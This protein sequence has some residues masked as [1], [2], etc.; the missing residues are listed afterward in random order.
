MLA[1]IVVLCS[2]WV[3]A[4]RAEAARKADAF[5]RGRVALQELDIVGTRE[6]FNAL[7]DDPE[8]EAETVLLRAGIL[9]ALGQPRQAIAELAAVQVRPD[10]VEDA[11]LLRANAEWRTGNAVASIT[12]LDQLTRRY[13]ASRLPQLKLI[14]YYHAIGAIDEAMRRCRALLSHH[15]EDPHVREM[16]A[17]MLHRDM[18]FFGD[19]AKE[20]R[21]A[22]R[23]SQPGSSMDQAR[24]SLLECLVEL[25]EYEELLQEAAL[26]PESP[27]RFTWQ[28]IAEKALDRLAD[29]EASLKLALELDPKYMPALDQYGRL[30]VERR[31]FAAAAEKFSVAVSLDE[32]DHKMRYRLAQALQF[33]GEKEKAAAEFEKCKASEELSRQM[34]LLYS[35]AKENPADFET[36][37]KLVQ[38]AEKMGRR[39][40]MAI[41]SQAAAQSRQ[42]SVFG[43]SPET[44][45]EA[46]AGAESSQ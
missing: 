19:A 17:V 9:T 20:Y 39:D 5:R 31:E 37:E 27:A 45:A 36:R 2:G 24:L 18:M 10:L 46:G 23:F 38:I 35:K 7:R 43:P 44:G 12:T 32:N 34:T 30:L 4:T 1:A 21:M 40:L 3:Y 25:H 16:L 6:A 29:A 28:A 8:F 15:M 13:P 14:H 41:W 33:S 42:L 22:I 11:G 26:L